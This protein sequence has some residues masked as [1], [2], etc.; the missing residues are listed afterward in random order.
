MF[1]RRFSPS[2]V[3]IGVGGV[4]RHSGILYK[5]GSFGR[6][7]GPYATRKPIGLF[8]CFFSSC[9]CFLSGRCLFAIL[10]V[11]PTGFRLLYLG[12]PRGHLWSCQTH[13]YLNSCENVFF[14]LCVAFEISHCQ[15]FCLI[16]TASPRRMDGWLASAPNVVVGCFIIRHAADHR[17]TL[18]SQTLPGACHRGFYLSLAFCFGPPE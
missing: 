6:P 4:C 8:H 11:F 13:S 9:C 15:P 5:L 10:R 17:R 16:I 2:E 1:T 18:S 3:G 14:C 12:W 7:P